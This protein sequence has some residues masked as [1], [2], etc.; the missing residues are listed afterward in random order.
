MGF[1]SIAG[2]AAVTPRQGFAGEARTREGPDCPG[3]PQPLWTGD[4]VRGAGWFVATVV[5]RAP[6]VGRIEGALDHDQSVVG[7]MALDIAAGRRF[8]IFFDGQ[9]YMGAVE[10]YMAAGFVRVLGHTPEVVALAPLMAFALFAAFQ[11]W[12]WSRWAD[13]RTG[14]FAAALAVTCGLSWLSGA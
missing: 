2:S 7:L 10:A 6:L 4:L 13:R 9:R 12:V 1:T 14:H 3:G 5:A 8:P 11:Y